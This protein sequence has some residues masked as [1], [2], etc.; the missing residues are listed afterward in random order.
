MPDDQV[1]P[2]LMNA[3]HHV[4]HDYANF[5]SSAKMRRKGK[6]SRGNELVPPVNTHVGHAFYLNCRKMADFLQNK[7]SGQN[8][9]VLAEHYLPGFKP[10]LPV[11]DRLRVTL[12][13]QLTHVTYARISDPHDIQRAEC[14]QME[15]EIRSEWRRFLLKLKKMNQGFADEF[16]RNLTERKNSEFGHC[17]LD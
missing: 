8:D 15:V 13:K 11:Y 5:A 10:C 6:D 2:K 9:D 12:N 17:D 4:V 1:D 3:I 16:E 7:K 14:K